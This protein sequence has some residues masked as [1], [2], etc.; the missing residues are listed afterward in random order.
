[1]E[2]AP[3]FLGPLPAV[4]YGSRKSMRAIMASEVIIDW[5]GKSGKT[6]RYW[7]L[8][9]IAAEGIQ[10]VSG[11]Y[12]FV[13]QLPNG[14]YLPLYFGEAQDL[15]ARIPCHDR[16]DDARRLGITHVMAHTTQGG[17]QVRLAEERDLI[18]QWNPTMNTHHRQVS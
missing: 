7:A 4:N 6:Y 16:L 3:I 11:N 5:P 13:K 1:L 17:E 15:R 10:A 14:N 9:T 18:Q 8:S 12:A 2:D